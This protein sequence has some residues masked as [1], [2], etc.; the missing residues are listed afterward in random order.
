M[1]YLFLLAIP[2]VGLL[3]IRAFY[4]DFAGLGEWLWFQDEYDAISQSIDQFGQ[5]SYLYIQAI[6]IIGVVV[7]CGAILHRKIVRLSQGSFPSPR[8]GTQ[9]SRRAIYD[10]GTPPLVRNYVAWAVH[11]NGFRY[12]DVTLHWPAAMDPFQAGLGGFAGWLSP[13]LWTAK[14]TTGGRHL[15]L[16]RTPVAYV[17]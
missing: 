13:L 8:A 15:P 11:H 4:R 3:V 7:V 14:K 10:H 12:A 16:E 9:D 1:V 6:H 2:I 5:S 17:Q